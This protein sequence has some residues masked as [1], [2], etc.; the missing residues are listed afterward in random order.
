VA[1]RQK[2]DA[3]EAEGE[4]DPIAPREAGAKDDRGGGGTAATVKPSNIGG[5]AANIALLAVPSSPQPNATPRIS[6]TLI[7][8]VEFTRRRRAR[9]QTVR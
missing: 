7:V 3:D 5:S 1:D 2:D 8:A 6:A 4:R 9:S